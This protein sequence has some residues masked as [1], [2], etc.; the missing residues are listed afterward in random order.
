[1]IFDLFSLPLDSLPFHGTI[2]K[3]VYIGGT[4]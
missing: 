2:L 3:S 1:M 4:V